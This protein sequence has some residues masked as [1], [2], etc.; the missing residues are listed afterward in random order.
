MASSARPPVDLKIRRVSEVEQR[1][2][3]MT[4]SILSDPD[5]ANLKIYRG[6]DLDVDNP[7]AADSDSWPV[8]FRPLP[9]SEE[10]RAAVT[11]LAIECDQWF[12]CPREDKHHMLE[13]ALHKAGWF[14]SSFEFVVKGFKHAGQP[15]KWAIIG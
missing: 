2:M 7:N 9:D 5:L 1:L 13:C 12:P 6:S 4:N 8:F 10:L 3:A 11:E 14:T 15:E